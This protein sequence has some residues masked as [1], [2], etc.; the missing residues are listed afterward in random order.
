MLSMMLLSML[1]LW[2]KLSMLVSVWH[3]PP[4]IAG[5]WWSQLRCY[6]SGSPPYMLLSEVNEHVG[7]CQCCLN[8]SLVLYL[9]F[10]VGF[11]FLFTIHWYV[12]EYEISITLLLGNISILFKSTQIVSLKM[13]SFICRYFIWAADVLYD[14]NLMISTSPKYNNFLSCAS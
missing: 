2:Q 6:S 8:C 1:V 10:R 4:L 14:L 12:V 11:H 5:H 13:S 9:F 3:W 7:D